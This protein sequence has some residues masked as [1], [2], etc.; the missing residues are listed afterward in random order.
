MA[1]HDVPEGVER[2]LEILVGNDWP[3]GS[4]GDLVSMA[5][6]WN[7]LATQVTGKVIPDVQTAAASAS[8]GLGEPSRDAFDTY[9]D[10][11]VGPDGY[12]AGLAQTCVGLAD[13]CTQ[14]AVEIST[15]RTLIIESLILLAVQIAIDIYEAFFTGGASLLQI[16]PQMIATRI[17]IMTLIRQTIIRLTSH[18]A[19]S[20]ANQVVMTVIAQGI[21][22]ARHHAH[23]DA[24]QVALAAEN[25]AIGGG[26][27]FG[28]GVLGKGLGSASKKGL[29]ALG[30]HLAVPRALTNHVPENL[31]DFAGKTVLSA[32]WGAASGAAEAAAQ[33]ASSHS[34]GDE[35]AGAENGM[36]G[37]LGGRMHE[38]L[39]P[40][41]KFPVTIGPPIDEKLNSLFDKGG[42]APQQNIP[43]QNHADNAD[44]GGDG[45]GDPKPK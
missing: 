29:G 30:I 31:V 37:G 3:A 17:S 27:G 20:V 42:N 21:A 41:G 13:S 24:G 38:I 7:N 9:I 28:M 1:E 11:L 14:M 15:L 2:L 33:D 10:S 16:A 34:S 22:D 25:G 40:N 36:F 4:E 44:V 26:V 35:I 43:L 8:A 39:N 12:M 23:F 19:E 45:D 32:G 6:A 5:A 18:M